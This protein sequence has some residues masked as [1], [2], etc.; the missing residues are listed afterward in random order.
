MKKYA[1]LV[2][3]SLFMFSVAL[4]AQESGMP[5]DGRN[6]M[7]QKREIKMERNH[8]M[9]TPQMRADRMAEQ[10]GLTETEKGKVK[11]FIEKQD[12]NC[13]KMADE[14]YK[15]KQEFKAKF[16]AQK[17]TNDA[18]LEKIIGKEKFQKLQ[19]LRTEKQEK[20]KEHMGKMR[21]HS[22]APGKECPAEGMKM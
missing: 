16:E 9:L 3:A 11:E 19:A 13:I 6:M 8:S 18:E 17:K 2:L 1:L 4:T 12:A 5:P 21:N 14:V 10:L 7:N 15:M 22:N 20:M